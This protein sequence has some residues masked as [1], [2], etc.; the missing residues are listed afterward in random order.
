ML[1]DKEDETFKELDKTSG[2]DDGKDET[3]DFLKLIVLEGG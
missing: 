3:L 2:V 1:V